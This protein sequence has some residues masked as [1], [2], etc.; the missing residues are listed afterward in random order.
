[1]SIWDKIKSLFGDKTCPD[2]NGRGQWQETGISE[3]MVN[4]ET[5]YCETCHGKGFIVKDEDIDDF[6]VAGSGVTEFDDDDE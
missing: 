6:D 4:Q 2:C 1:M 5:Y 3:G